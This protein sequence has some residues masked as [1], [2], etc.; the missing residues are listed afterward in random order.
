MGFFEKK[1]EIFQ[2]RHMCQFFLEC[3]SNGIF[4]LKMSFY[5]IFE[6]FFAKIRQ[7]FKVGKLTKFYEETEF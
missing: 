1:L 5:L 4:F 3:V 6:A 2:I 7:K